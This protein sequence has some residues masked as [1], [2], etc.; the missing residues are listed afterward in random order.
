[1]HIKSDASEP[2]GPP[3]KSHLHLI[4]LPKKTN[5]ADNVTAHRDCLHRLETWLP[6]SRRQDS[7]I[8]LIAADS[9]LQLIFRRLV[10]HGGMR[11][12]NQTG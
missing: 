9:Q 6:Y 1:M 10:I 4:M 5:I 11:V 7:Q 2:A 3:T 8:V 12:V